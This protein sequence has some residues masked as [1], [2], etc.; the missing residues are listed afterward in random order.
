MRDDHAEQRA[1][2]T[3]EDFGRCA[4]VHYREGDN[5]LRFDAELLS[6]DAVVGVWVPVERWDENHPWA[7][8]RLRAILDVVGMEVVRQR[9]PGCRAD[10]EEVTGWIS[11]REGGADGRAGA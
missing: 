8:G 5:H 11:I 2:V 6:G 4:Y 1:T 7:A 10:I 3:I 9:A